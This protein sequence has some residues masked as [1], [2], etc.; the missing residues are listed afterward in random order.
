MME[1]K[2]QT[3]LRGQSTSFPNHL[4]LKYSKNVFLGLRQWKENENNSLTR[5]RTNS[6]FFVYPGKIEARTRLRALGELERQ[7][8]ESERSGVE[9]EWFVRLEWPRTEIESHI[10]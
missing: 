4:P 1:E 3:F 2:M 5:C 10:L 9:L 8:E 7:L 6:D